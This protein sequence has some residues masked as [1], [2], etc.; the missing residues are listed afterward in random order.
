[1]INAIK[2]AQSGLL[3]ATNR[4][5]VAA[6]NIV[7]VNSAGQP[8]FSVEPSAALQGAL[9][10]QPRRAVNTPT[11]GGGVRGA[12]QP[13]SPATFSVFAPNTPA[14][15]SSGLVAYPNVS[16][17]REFTELK[18]A[19]HAYKANAVVIGA[20]DEALGEVIDQTE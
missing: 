17:A 14:A 10:Y 9:A 11:P 2:I 3:A 8:A 20:L 7:N 18:L 12:S 13:I 16:L 4:T 15:D 19:E 6:R 1:M 5:Q